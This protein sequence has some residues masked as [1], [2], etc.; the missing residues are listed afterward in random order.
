MI[1][2]FLILNRLARYQ[3]KNKFIAAMSKHP[4]VN[5]IFLL[6]AGGF[7][8]GYLELTW[9]LMAFI[10]NQAFF[11]VIL[12]TKLIQILFF[13]G[14]GVAVM[15]SLTTAIAS[16]FMS[17]DLEFHFSLPVNFNAWIAHRFLQ[18]FI[19]SSWMLMA[20]GSPFIWFYLT[21][22]ETSIGVRILGVL[23]FAMVCSL[24]V[25]AAV[26]L[27][28]LM[29][30]VFP[31][32]RLHQ[33]LLVLTIMLAGGIILLFRYMEPE[34]FIGPGGIEKFRGYIDLVALD[35]FQWNPAIWAANLVTALN[36]GEW[37][38]ALSHAWKLILMEIGAFGLL[39]LAF[40][41][42]YR[43]SWDRALQS[44]SGEASEGA[45]NG[46]SWLSGV[47]SSHQWG[48]EGREFL[49]FLR[50]PSQWSQ[51]F[52][53][54]MLLG[55]YLFSISKIP[56][57]PFGGSL[58]HLA[59]GNTA[60]VAFV[61]LSLTSRFVFASFSADGMA[62]WLMKSSPG[63]WSKFI[64]SKVLVYGLPTVIFAELLAVLSG[65]I[66]RL[67][68]HELLMVGLG[69]LWDSGGAVLLGAAFG[70]IFI[71]PSVENPLKMV[72]STG[73]FLL[74]ACGSFMVGLHVLLRLSA[75]SYQVN[76]LLGHMGWPDLQGAYAVW[77]FVGL[78]ALEAV[79]LLYLFRRGM[80][81]LQAGDFT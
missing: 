14:L 10:Y 35:R 27:S 48:Q 32:R 37:L 73:G 23:T 57:N 52:V 29:V 43:P 21:L 66:M 44:M 60:F 39:F 45:N 49:L 1:A 74:M 36:Q 11:G 58:Y 15:S 50:D 3:A 62:L 70:M 18:I 8:W 47:L 25:V 55:L 5:S 79:A 77:Y 46:D 40:H 41:R 54:L 68:A 42:F 33:M 24:P 80:R 76:Y 67:E 19:Q 9:M 34:Q 16:L 6:I 20:F 81:H 31:A 13:L 7:F 64:R 51:I 17:Q 61:C 65:Y 30:R 22:G 26:L 53:M 71:D 28:L 38:A 2:D 56:E 69:C 4:V 12:A 78:L 63:G 75:N 72:V 59:L